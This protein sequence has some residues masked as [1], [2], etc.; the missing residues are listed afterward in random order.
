MNLHCKAAGIALALLIWFGGGVNQMA[1]QRPNVVV[2]Y[3]D[4]IGYGDFGCYGAKTISTPRID[5]LAANGLRFTSGYAT[6]A[7]CTP[8]RFSIL[9]G[10][11][12]WRK[13][14]R[15]IAPPN[16]AALIQPGVPTIASVLRDAGYRTAMI[17]KWHLG[18][19]VPPKPD[20]SGEIKPGPLEVGFDECF[21]M[22]TTNDRVP[23][24]YVRDHRI[25]GLDPTDPVDVF[26][27][28]PDGQATGVTDRDRLRVD[29]SHEHNDSVVNGIGRIGFMVGG[30]ACRWTDEEMADTFV[31]EARKFLKQNHERPFFLFYSAHQAHVPRAPHPRFVGSTPHGPRGDAIAEFDWCVG[32][33]VEELRANGQLD[34]TL[35]LISSDNGPVLDDGYQDQAVELLGEHRPAGPYRGGKYSRFEGGTRVPWIVHWPARIKPGASDA[36]ISQVDVLASLATIAGTNIPKG[37]ASDSLD[38]SATLTGESTQGREFVVEHSGMA[39][40]LAIRQG[41]WKYI[42][43]SPG[44]AVLGGKSAETA[45]HRQDQLYNLADDAGERRNVARSHPAKVAELKSLLAS[46]RASDPQLTSSGGD[47]TGE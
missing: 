25:V 22:P 21:I 14:G 6:S 27:T 9:T 46:V 43:P 2:I 20:W 16:G 1:A 39:S 5:E 41:D 33:I 44:P 11:Y 4:D 42:E 29:W 47:A 3:A 31:G 28:N 7:T 12:S 24:V 13:P 26:D 45:N 18:L 15:G 38:L 40:A 32:Q 30:N 36:L 35:I 19:G 34:N 8:S 17:G 37:A 23:C 10:D